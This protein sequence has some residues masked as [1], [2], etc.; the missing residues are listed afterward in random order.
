MRLEDQAPTKQ[1]D[2]KEVL[3]VQKSLLD[4]K[5]KSLWE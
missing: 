1:V 5:W 2:K 4:A 3:R